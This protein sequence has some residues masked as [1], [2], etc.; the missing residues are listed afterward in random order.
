MYTLYGFW[1]GNTKKVLHVLEELQLEYK[2]QYVD[3]FKGENKTA[4][5]LKLNPVDKVPVLEHIGSK[6]NKKV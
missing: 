4:A 2:F 1:T 6:R 3:L 5:F